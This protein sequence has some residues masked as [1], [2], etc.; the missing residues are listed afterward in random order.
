MKGVIDG[1]WPIHCVCH[2]HTSYDVFQCVMQPFPNNI[3]V[4]DDHNQLAL[5]Y[6]VSRC[7]VVDSRIIQ[8]LCETSQDM[9][10]QSGKNGLY[11]LHCALQ[12][13]NASDEII[14]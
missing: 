5:H 9:I 4:K 2:Y 11:A 8:D 12:C 14:W 6:A 10:W 13:T 3:Y 1:M 7:C